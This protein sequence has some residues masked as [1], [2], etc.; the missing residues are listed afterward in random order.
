MAE[1][2]QNTVFGYF[3]RLLSRQRIFPYAEERDSSLWKKYVHHDM[4][5]Q[6][7]LHGHTG[8]ETPE[9]KDE[10][11]N[12]QKSSRE[13]SST[14]NG[15]QSKNTLGHSVDPEKGKDVS[16]IYWYNDNDQEV[17]PVVPI[18]IIVRRILIK[19]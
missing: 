1:L 13:T 16:V 14:R 7:A 4:S 17:F 18:S 3:V 9:E 19:R 6:M 10:G 2:F 8:D 11:V 5:Q 15:G 12:T